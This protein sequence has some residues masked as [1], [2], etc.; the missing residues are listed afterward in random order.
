MGEFASRAAHAGT[1][2][3]RGNHTPQGAKSDAT[4]TQ[5][6]RGSL[7]QRVGRPELQS[8]HEQR[9]R[10]DRVRREIL[11]SEAAKRRTGSAHAL[12]QGPQGHMSRVTRDSP[13]AG[14]A[15]RDWVGLS[16]LTGGTRPDRSASRQR[17]RGELR[18]KRA[19]HHE[20]DHVVGDAVEFKDGRAQR[21]QQHRRQE[22]QQQRLWQ[23]TT[24]K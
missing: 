17:Q 18:R 7:R 6:A 24:R 4:I 15:A 16:S 14:K 21:Q 9:R 11:Y 12:R 1:T 23:G 19:T 3:K 13:R 2:T 10:A 22:Q 5:H 8:D 20:A